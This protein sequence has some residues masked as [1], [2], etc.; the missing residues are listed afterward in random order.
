M[1]LNNRKLR[2]EVIR[3][4]TGVVLNGYNID[5]IFLIRMRQMTKV[6]CQ[7]LHVSIIKEAGCNQLIAK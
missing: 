5:K 7:V 3:T 2:L 4:I 1:S 6:P